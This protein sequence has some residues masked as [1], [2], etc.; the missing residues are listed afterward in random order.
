MDNIFFEKYNKYKKKYLKEKN[1]RNTKQ[2]KQLGGGFYKEQDVVNDL[3]K[4]GGIF[5]SKQSEELSKFSTYKRS[6]AT[7]PSNLRDASSFVPGS[8]LYE[9]GSPIDSNLWSSEKLSVKLGVHGAQRDELIKSLSENK[10]TFWSLTP[11]T[12]FDRLNIFIPDFRILS[13]KYE[14]N[15]NDFNYKGIKVEDIP[16]DCRNIAGFDWY[17]TVP[18]DLLADYPSVQNDLQ[19]YKPVRLDSNRLRLSVANG[20]EGSGVR[21]GGSNIIANKSTCQKYYGQN[22]IHDPFIDMCDIVDLNNLKFIC[23]S[24][25]D[26]ARHFMLFMFYEVSSSAVIIKAKQV[27]K[28]LKKYSN[29]PD[30]PIIGIGP[31]LI[32]MNIRNIND[33]TTG[34][35]KW[36]FDSDLFYVKYC[37]G[38]I[39]FH[40]LYHSMAHEM[41]IIGRDSLYAISEYGFLNSDRWDKNYYEDPSNKKEKY[42]GFNK[43]VSVCITDLKVYTDTKYLKPYIHLLSVPSDSGD[44]YDNINATLVID[45]DVDANT[46]INF[47]YNIIG[48]NEEQIT[49][50]KVILGCCTKFG[51]EEWDMKQ[52]PLGKNCF[53]TMCNRVYDKHNYNNSVAEPVDPTYNKQITNVKTKNTKHCFRLC[54]KHNKQCFSTLD[55]H[56]RPPNCN[57]VTYNDASKECVL[58]EQYAN[59]NN[60]AHN[61]YI[62]RD[63]TIKTNQ[64]KHMALDE[65]IAAIDNTTLDDCNELCNNASFNCNAFN[66]NNDTCSYGYINPD[67]NIVL[68]DVKGNIFVDKQER[69]RKTKH[70]KP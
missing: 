10:T 4:Y 41:Y 35:N 51:G 57:A 47:Q 64:D 42:L 69:Y 55:E 52:C 44:T 36:K 26:L 67:T 50:T 6:I 19:F 58:Y 13:H 60:N 46:L 18:I 37:N 63:T 28:L 17:K 5:N 45:E 43:R 68:D 56:Q 65:E 59:D 7:V 39:Q 27:T 61:V 3:A 9:K 12:V 66:F 40:N 1:N 16:P 49:N 38:Y 48:T 14:W 34:K 33:K 32:T 24:Q 29:A 31:S 53:R 11:L 8:F 54:D 70:K 15:F 21:L 22:E 30:S 20:K 62:P 25:N 2:F 23:S